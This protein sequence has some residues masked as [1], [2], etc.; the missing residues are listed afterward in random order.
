MKKLLLLLFTI[1][2]S[3][4]TASA[5][6]QGQPLIDSILTELPKAKEDTN[7]VLLLNDLSFELFSINPNE[8]LK[9]ANQQLELANKLGWQKGIAKAYSSMGT[10]KYA[11]SDYTGALDSYFKSLTISEKLDDKKAMASTLGNMGSINMRIGRIPKSREYFTKA[12]TIYQTLNNK[13]GIGRNLGNIGNL[14]FYDKDYDH[15]IE[16][17]QKA[18][19]IFE[20]LSDQNQ[21]ALNLGNIGNIYHD[22]KEFGS[23]LIYFDKAI[24]IYEKMG[25]KGGV[26]RNYYNAGTTYLEQAYSSLKN[27]ESKLS[28]NSKDFKM[29]IDYIQKSIAI[30]IEIED[31]D[32]LIN[33]Y[34]SL[35]SAYESSGNASQSLLY[36]KKYSRLKDSVFSKDKLN[37]IMQKESKFELEK[38]AAT[39]SVKANEE[40]KVIKAE[41]KQE[42]TKSYAL[43]GGVALLLVFGGFM[44]NRFKVTQKQKNIIEKQKDVV[45]DKNREITK[46]IEYALRIQTAIL[47]PAR[48]VKQYLDNSFILYKPK[49]I[50][51]GDFYW[52]ETVEFTDE[53]MKRYT[54]EVHPHIGTSAHQIILFAACDCTGHGVPGAMVSVVCHN[55]LNRAVREFGLTTPSL[56]LDKT[57]EIVKENFSKSEEDIKDGMDISLCAYNTKTKTL[58]WAGANNPLWIIRNNIGHQTS[59]IRQLEETKADKQP[60]G[61]H[62]NYKPFTNHQLILTTG[63][64]IYLFTDGFADQFGG[65]TGQ[66][67]LTRK[68]FKDLLLSIQSK[69]MQEQGIAL[70]N[71]IVDYRKEVEQIDDIL[72]MGVRV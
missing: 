49:D 8:G 33:G 12:L 61:M 60:I 22:K 39:D 15:A 13:T 72:V 31:L 18:L 52:M 26:S 14:Y 24:A 57:A 56:I 58:E 7:K 30:S 65:E 16:Y 20:E 4:F 5:Q 71:F 51:A 35:S 3:V 28:P 37:E 59:D 50:V 44:F 43:Y 54:D 34:E 17:M 10:N 38:R 23:A 48:V 9:Y 66:K 67:K 2:C 68:R 63:D 64:S 70:E 47:P 69:S 40:Q 45:E 32:D 19:K 36:F 6:K 1:T 55:A 25:D 27:S 53:T 21:I 62:E 42:Q 29:A 11:K 46:S 41:L